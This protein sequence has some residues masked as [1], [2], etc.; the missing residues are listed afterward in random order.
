MD[1]IVLFKIESLHARTVQ[2]TGLKIRQKGHDILTGIIV[3]TLNENAAP[4]ANLA[5]VDLATGAIQLH[6]AILATL[7]FLADAFASGSV[8]HKDSAPIRATLEESGQVASDGAR[9]E[10]R[11]TAQI[12]P[13]SVLGATKV[14]LHN[15]L[16]QMTPEDRDPTSGPVLASGQVVRCT[17][18]P[19]SSYLDV[20]LPKN[21][22]GGS[23]RLNLI[24]GFLLV[25]I[26]TLARP[27]PPERT[28]R[29]K[30]SRK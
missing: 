3:A 26:V 18:V 12:K 13:G 21:M 9:F 25:P 20:A 22:G 10:V 29:T 30:R 17:F 24:G 8:P 14:S 23:Q 28:G 1:P 7:P 27:E 15:N 2:E 4:P 11:G 16:V 19:E 6:W 5:L